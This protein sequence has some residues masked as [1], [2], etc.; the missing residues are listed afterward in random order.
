MKEDFNLIWEISDWTLQARQIIESIPKFPENSS[1]I[2]IIRHSHRIDT[3][4][5]QLMANLGL[6]DMGKEIAKIFGSKLPKNRHIRLN[7]STVPRCKETANSILDGFQ[8]VGGSGEILGLCEPLYSIGKDPDFVL[9]M[10]YKYPGSRFINHWAVGLFPDE[11]IQK[12]T[13]Y[14]IQAANNI[15]NK[16]IKGNSININI[17]HDLILMALRYG[18]FGIPPGKNWVNFLG[19]FIMA[20]LKDKIILSD[21]NGFH[22]LEVPHWFRS[23]L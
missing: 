15:W 14:A 1:L 22:T 4:D 5:M 19:G 23:M 17:T 2:I 16:S 18:W 12:F 21:Q 6:T 10:A 20:I 8:T 7:H 3:A 9:K 11:S 13:R